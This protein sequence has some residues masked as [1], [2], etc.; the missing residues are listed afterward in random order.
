M[1]STV[2][3]TT[4]FGII[5][6]YVAMTGILVRVVSDRINDLGGHLG[7]RMERL[8]TRFDR[9]DE[10]FDRV[11]ERFDR[12]EERVNEHFDRVNQR[13]DH[14]D[15]RIGRAEVRA[16]ERDRVYMAKLN[17]LAESVARLTDDH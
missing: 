15:E 4:V 7:G 8:D 14:L 9:V 16:D 17:G 11:G 5:A 1:N 3:I 13:I 12:V 2:F 6:G 10:R